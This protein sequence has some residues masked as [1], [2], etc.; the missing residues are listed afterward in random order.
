M[1]TPEISVIIVNYN[2]KKHLK[3][4]L[5][6]L[7]SQS[8]KDFEVIIVD[9]ASW[10]GSVEFVKKYYPKRVRLIVNKTN[11]GFCGGNNDGIK[12]AQGNYL[13]LLNNDTVLDKDCLYHLYNFI[14]HSDERC[15]AVFPKV[16]FYHTPCFI[17]SAGVVWNYKNFWRDFRIGLLDFGQFKGSEK[18]FG[19][20]FVGVL[21]KKDIFYKMGLFDENLFTYGEDFDVCY[22]ANLLGYDLYLVPE[23]II[24]HKFR[25]SSQEDRDPLW[26]Y[27]LFLR[28]YYYVIFKNLSLR[29]IFKS[30]PF[31]LKL[32]F[33]NLLW[34]FQNKEYKR[35]WLAIKVP[36]GLLKRFP[37][38]I[39][40]RIWLQK[41]RKRRDEEFWDF[42]EREDHNIFHYCNRPVLNIL[43]V[44]T[45]LYG[46][47]LYKKD[48]KDFTT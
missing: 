4:N 34:G 17:N 29:S 45:A 35:F 40:K 18:I 20:M 19:A 1:K 27:Y 39:K 32:Y 12:A 30:L 21:I 31:L 13:F 24:Y 11:R 26:S 38:L 14:S 7:F 37:S 28:N 9:N 47:I 5:S 33:L 25:S 46:S 44:K 15:F 10:D 8:F 22:Q 23:A 48:G 2:G 42:K 43:N 6:S 41:N 36:L 16:L 3:E